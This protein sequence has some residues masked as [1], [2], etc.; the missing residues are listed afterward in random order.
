M[1]VG[2]GVL[3]S[4]D[5]SARDIIS[6]AKERTIIGYAGPDRPIIGRSNSMKRVL[7]LVEKVAHLSEHVL[8]TGETGTGKELVARAIHYL[9]RGEGKPFLRV[10]CSVTEDGW[11]SAF[12]GHENG[13]FTGAC[14]LKKG[15]FE[16]AGDGTLL[17]DEINEVLGRYQPKLLRVLGENEYIRMGGKE[18]LSSKARVITSTSED[19]EQL[20]EQ[21][22]FSQGLMYR[23]KTL[24]I[25]VPSLRDR[26]EDIPLL[27]GYYI[28]KHSNGRN[29]VM[30][31]EAMKLLKDY[32]W[33][34]NVREL[35]N[36]VKEAVTYLDIPV[37]I[38]GNPIKIGKEYFSKLEESLARNDRSKRNDRRKPTINYG[39][40]GLRKYTM[41]ME[42]GY[43]IDLLTEHGGKIGLAAKA[44]EVDIKTLY[45]KLRLHGLGRKDFIPK[46]SSETSISRDA[47]MSQKEMD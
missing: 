33:P 42:K 43:F 20:V 40:V 38:N 31:E 18:I 30:S 4:L 35:E 9:G 1:I 7:D 22:R 10:N 41:Q 23:L 32:P 15:Y 21:K 17:L 39:G 45:R 44:A 14:G 26:G 5:Y 8:I 12:F 19:L 25:D 46:N 13:A 47:R 34:G 16:L 2:D 11:E 27:V 29:I 24:T 36:A 6:P 28:N 37:N 3:G